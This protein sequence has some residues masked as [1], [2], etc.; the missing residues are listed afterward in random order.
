MSDR[1]PRLLMLP[2]N[3]KF[4][5]YKIWGTATNGSNIR[6][7]ISDLV[8]HVIDAIKKVAVIIAPLMPTLDVVKIDF[9]IFPQA[10][11]YSAPEYIRENGDRVSGRTHS[12]PVFCFPVPIREF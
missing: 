4:S 3:P 1:L 2:Y 10:Q 11:I 12:V 8:L 9:L 5:A 6:K 7:C